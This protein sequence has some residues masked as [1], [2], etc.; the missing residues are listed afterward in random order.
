MTVAQLIVSDF[1]KHKK[2]GANFFVIVFFTQGFWATFQYRLA[3]YIYR[4][5]IVFSY[6]V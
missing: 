2:Y 1:M 4:K 6:I 3:N 5:I